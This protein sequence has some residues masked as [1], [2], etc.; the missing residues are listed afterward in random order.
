M[1]C[2]N[3]IFKFFFAIISFFKLSRKWAFKKVILI[4]TN[5]S[6]ISAKKQLF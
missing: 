6:T 1:W 5:F 3:L 2:V 4:A